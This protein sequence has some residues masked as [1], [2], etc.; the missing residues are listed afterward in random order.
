MYWTNEKDLPNGFNVIQKAAKTTQGSPM[1]FT[2]PWCLPSLQP[3]EAP[4]N[5]APRAALGPL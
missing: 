3:F 2:S 5:D 1:R 4:P